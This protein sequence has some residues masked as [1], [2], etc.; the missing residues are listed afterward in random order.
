MELFLW[1]AAV[2]GIWLILVVLVLAIL[3]GGS[4]LY[5]KQS[6]DDRYD[7]QDPDNWGT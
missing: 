2:V 1:L 3:G 6:E 7:V 5:R 4:P